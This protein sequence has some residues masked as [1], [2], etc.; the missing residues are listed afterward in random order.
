MLA[1]LAR[2]YKVEQDEVLGTFEGGFH[3]KGLIRRQR[4]SSRYF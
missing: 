3:S 2:W 4:L 1:V